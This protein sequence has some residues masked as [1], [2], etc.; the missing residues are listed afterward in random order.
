MGCSMTMT[1]SQEITAP[2]RLIPTLLAGFD[3]ITNHILLIL[4]PFCLDLLIWFTLQ[5]RLKNIIEAILAEM[6]LLS[7]NEGPELTSMIEAGREIPVAKEQAG[8]AGGGF[9]RGPLL[10]PLVAATMGAAEQPPEA[11][12]CD[13]EE[14]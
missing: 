1:D 5:L 11:V 12:G 4:F 10:L 2:P 8:R 14:H 13:I 7:A 9:A 6:V 3:A